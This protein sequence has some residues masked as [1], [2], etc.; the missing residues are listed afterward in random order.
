VLISCILVD[1]SLSRSLGPL[2][3]LQNSL[4]VQLPSRVQIIEIH[5]CIEHLEVAAP[6]LTTPD[7]IIREDHDVT[8]P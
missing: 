8:L 6:R 7:G 4:L 2:G 5:D 1:R 3:N